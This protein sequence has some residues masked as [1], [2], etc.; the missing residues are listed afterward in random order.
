MSATLAIVG[1]EIGARRW[2]WLAITV[3][4]AVGFYLLQLLALVVRFDALPN[5]VIV[6]DWPS[7]ILT[8]FRST[9]ALSDALAI[10]QDEWLLEIGYMNGDFGTPISEW[11]L[12]VL[13]AMAILVVALGALVATNIL[14]LRSLRRRC[15]VGVRAGGGAAT[16]LGTALVGLSSLSLYWVVCCAAPSWIVGLTMLGMGVGTALWIQPAGA[17][18]SIAGFAV[19][20]FTAVVLARRR[21]ALG[22][23]ATTPAP[24]RGRRRAL[25][26][27]SCSPAS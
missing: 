1:R 3:G 13:P 22:P 23:V 6:Y 9:P 26:E 11:S 27:E 2:S 14:L 17:W 10:A 25:R 19:L 21:A 7:N 20:A 4:C 5:Y 15:P 12:T 24:V 8:I 16:G 18:V